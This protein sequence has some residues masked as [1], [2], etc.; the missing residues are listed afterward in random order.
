MKPKNQIISLALI[1]LLVA[2]LCG[3]GGG[4]EK[5]G[6]AIT[7]VETT[8]VGDI[9]ARPDDFTGKTVK[10]EGEIARECPTGCWLD[11]KDETGVTYVDLGPSGFAIPQKV[12]SKITIEGKV[13]KRP[14]RTMIIGKGVEIQ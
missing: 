14:E 11:L 3:C 7:T 5:F 2:A 6:D 1:A 10:I 12:G 4:G 13:L 8:K 9:L